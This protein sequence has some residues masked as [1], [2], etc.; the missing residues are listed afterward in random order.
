MEQYIKTG[1]RV[2]NEESAALKLLAKKLD[3]SFVEA[4]YELQKCKG[5]IVLSGMGKSGHIAKKIVAT[6]SSTGTPSIFVH[7]AEANH[8]D[9]G[10]V[11]KG[12]VVI[13]ISKSGES[14]ELSGLLHYCKR[15]KI[16][17]IGITTNAE[18]TLGNS[19]DIK[20]LL[21]KV[22]EA[23][24]LG[25]AP[26]TSAILTLALGDALAVTLSEA[27]KFTP[28]EFQKYHPGGKLGQKLMKIKEV[29]SAEL[30]LLTHDK[31]LKDAILVMNAGRLGCV[32]VI[33][34]KNELVGI[35]TDGDLRRN[36][37]KQ[38]LDTPIV[39][40]MTKNPLKITP[41][42][43]VEDLIVIMQEKRIPS[44]FVCKTN[45]PVGVV[46]IHNLIQRGFI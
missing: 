29:M 43:Y 10:M 16:P 31:K 28:L 19:S 3:E 44:I 4:I 5:R 21:P 18:S 7:P 37:A 1:I 6:F 46:H 30:P 15:N 22:K 13:A 9:L 27:K 26:T 39:K 32:G 11:L 42:K 2:I 34:F 45:K 12:D 25:L 38:N 23:C 35:F 36:I 41:D 17:L 40:L 20:L 14:P 33:N 24:T 8:G